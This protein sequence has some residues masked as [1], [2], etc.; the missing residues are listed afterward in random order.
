MS[1]TT[2]IL[3]Q[4]HD[5]AVIRS[6]S[7]AQCAELATAIRQRIRQ[8]VSA[9]GGHLASN[10]GTVELTIAL[11]RALD[12]RHDRLLFDVGHQA[13][14]HKLLTGRQ[15]AFDTI[16]KAGGLS[17]FPD[18]KES[19]FDLAKVGH[20]STAISTA[21]GIAEADRQL[22]NKRE[23]VAMIGDGALTGGM[24]FEGL[25]NAGASR[26]NIIVL[27][28]DNGSFIDPPVGAMH[29]YLD[30]LRSGPTYNQL[31]DRVKRWLD[32]MHLKSVANRAH[33]AAQR[34]LS[35]GTLFEE[36]GFRYF[37]PIDGHDIAATERLIQR[38]GEL[39]GPRLVHVHTRKGAGWD[40]AE[41]DPLKWHGPKGFDPETGDALP[42]KA[43]KDAAQKQ[44]RRTYSVVAADAIGS[45]AT[46]DQR[47]V[48]VTA[49]MPTGTGLARIAKAHPD[50]VI[51]VGIC[52]QHSVGLAQGMVLGGLLPWLC[53]YSTFA[54]RGFDQIFQELVVQADLGVPVTLDRAGLVGEDGETHQ[55]LYDIAWARSLPG[56]VL[57]AP[58]DGQ[59]LVAMLQYIQQRRQEPEGRPAAWFI[60]YPKEFVPD[61]TW[62]ATARNEIAAGNG[63]ILRTATVEA[64]VVIWAYGAMV[65][66]I[67]RVAEE[68][69]A[70]LADRLTIVNARFAKPLDTRLLQQTASDA[71][72]LI[73]VEDHTLPGGFGSGVSEWLHDEQISVPLQRWGV[74]DTL[75]AHAS[76]AQQLASQQLDEA[77]LRQRIV[78][79]LSPDA[80]QEPLSFPASAS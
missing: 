30:R 25:I 10:L 26:A 12:F 54:Q 8:V 28:N 31:R 46:D 16:R 4:L 49:A 79:I 47:V 6:W 51:D 60:R 50:R 56:T 27:L 18:P 64:P 21:L 58:K 59:E 2:D 66:R 20:S 34:L 67:W 36:L 22:G 57:M 80:G 38:V 63:Q 39:P 37:G 1:E 7:S 61:C 52:E 69:P 77:G 73:T 62:S 40:I 48:A 17:G 76:R 24:A 3:E 33:D 15:G 11:H 45:F 68:L 78:E 9:N 13:Y 35:T 32:S 75:I 53:H 41:A 43:Q 5:P 55:G 23:V 65:H 44:H 71:S 74:E 70:E 72:L 19:P 14:P 42:S 29:T